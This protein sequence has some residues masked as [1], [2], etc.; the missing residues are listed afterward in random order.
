MRRTIVPAANR[1]V[2]SPAI[3]AGLAAGLALAAGSAAR[4]KAGDP[5][6]AQ[7]VWRTAPQSA[8]NWLGMENPSYSRDM[9]TP[10][11]LLGHR[12]IA[13]CSTESANERMPNRTPSWGSLKAALKRTRPAVRPPADASA[14]VTLLCQNRVSV[15]GLESLFRVD[16]V[17]VAGTAR[18]TIFQQYF[19]KHQ[20]QPVRLPQDLR[21]IPP[22]DAPTSVVCRSI[23]STGQLADA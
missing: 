6:W 19:T 4:A 7:C 16:L 17:R 18:T 20:G 12:L 1:G 3:A 2:L 22:A 9:G 10:A 13:I 5:A 23:T 21:A 14:P 15:D 8:Q 11:E